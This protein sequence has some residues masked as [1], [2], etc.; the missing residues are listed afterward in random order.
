MSASF[1]GNACFKSIVDAS[2]MKHGHRVR[3]ANAMLMKVFFSRA[4]RIA[5]QK[6]TESPRVAWL[7]GW[8]V[9]AV[10]EA[11]VGETE[12]GCRPSVTS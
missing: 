4:A 12:S 11:V 10:V 2:G 3:R 1:C 7:L 9:G 5:E 8:H 6:R